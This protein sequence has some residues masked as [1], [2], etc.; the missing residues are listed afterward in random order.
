MEWRWSKT[1]AVV[2]A[3]SLPI[4]IPVGQLFV[5]SQIWRKRPVNAQNCTC[6]CWDTIFKGP[7]EYGVPKYKHLYFNVDRVTLRMWIIT[8][9]GVV[10]LYESM[11]HFTLLLLDKKLRWS[12]GILFLSSLY[13]H[14]YGWWGCLNFLNDGFYTMW[15]HQ[16]FFSFTELL[17]SL[18]VFS[19][20]DA[21]RG[22][23]PHSM[24]VI[25]CIAIFH[26]LCSG[27]DQF[28]K[29]V[30]LMR[31]AY[32]QI[33]KDLLLMTSDVLHATLSLL[34]IREHASRKGVTLISF[35][36]QRSL[37]Y[38]VLVVFSSMSLLVLQFPN[39]E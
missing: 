9:V 14:Y 8:V 11:K 29:N 25:C 12:M 20:L 31:G 28:I 34:E 24:L 30:L 10:F 7:Y 4:I 13:S 33:S 2:F 6:S 1:L 16:L 35:L 32:F 3:L 37:L 27:S 5:F 17:S 26:I 23:E 22:V 18:L 19:S 38:V 15:Y 36:S 21:K 39:R